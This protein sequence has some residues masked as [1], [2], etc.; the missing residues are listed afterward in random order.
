MSQVN[1][2][3]NKIFLISKN[4]R[5]CMPFGKVRPSHSYAQNLPMVSHFS[6][7]KIFSIAYKVVHNLAPSYLLEFT[8]YSSFICSLDYSKTDLPSEFFD[9]T[10]YAPPKRPIYLLVPLPGMV[11][12][13]YFMDNFL[14]SF[15]FVAQI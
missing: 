1:P 9:Y 7:N 4:K 14:T 8:F 10:R 11:F 12:P 13:R 5:F 2:G 6:Q 3:K 15:K